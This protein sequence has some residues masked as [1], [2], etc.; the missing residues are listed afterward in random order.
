MRL[1][2][3]RHQPR[4]AHPLPSGLWSAHRPGAREVVDAVLETCEVLMPSLPIRMPQ[5]GES[6]SRSRG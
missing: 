5:L 3:A 1:R 4:H 2:L 6:A